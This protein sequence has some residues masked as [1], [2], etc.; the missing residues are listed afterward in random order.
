MS[1]SEDDLGAL[2]GALGKKI[3][4]DD[5]SQLSEDEMAD[6]LDEGLSAYRQAKGDES[7]ALV[8]L[9]VFTLKQFWLAG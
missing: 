6:L 5:D 4:K 3:S 1:V 7:V 8:G 9:P 2:L